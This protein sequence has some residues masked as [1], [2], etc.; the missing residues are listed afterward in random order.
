[1][2]LLRIRETAKKQIAEASTPMSTAPSGP[3]EPAAGVIVARPAIRP[4]TAPMSP[5]RPNFTHSM[6]IHVSAAA[7][8]ERWVTSMAWPADWLA[9]RAEPAL[10]PY[11]PTHS[12]AAPIITST[13]LCGGR[14]SCGKCFLFPT[15]F[16]TTSADDPA[17]AWTTSPPAKSRTP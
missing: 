16:A 7:D 5:G 13:G 14:I 12:I 6:A 3:T 8:A 1:L 15:S 2:S 10:K 11:Q 17:V 4:V 9:P